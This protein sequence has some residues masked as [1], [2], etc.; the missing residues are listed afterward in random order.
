LVL[1]FISYS[2]ID[3]KF[4]GELKSHLSVLIRNNEISTFYDRDIAVG[5]YLDTS[6]R[7]NMEKASIIFLLVSSDFLGSDYCYDIEMKFAFEL[8]ATNQSRIV[9]V[10]IRPCDWRSTEL[11]KYLVA[12][13]DGV[14]ISLWPNKDSA[15]LDVVKQVRRALSEV[16]Q[17]EMFG[18]APLRQLPQTEAGQRAK[19]PQRFSPVIPRIRRERTDL[20]RS[21]YLRDSFGFIR[22]YF[23]E[24][25]RQLKISD[26]RVDF[27]IEPVTTRHFDVQVFIDGSLAAECAVKLQTERG[28][29]EITYSTDRGN[30]NSYNAAVGVDSDDYDVF[31]RGTFM[32][33]F[34]TGGRKERFSPDEVAQTFWGML[35]EQLQFS[36]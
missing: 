13:T 9:P 2:H 12:P 4:V 29:A 16:S 35:M 34:S 1:A 21:T 26:S 24:G 11:A 27:E 5:S 15:Y 7:Q 22:T 10:I 18:V 30:R 6:I 25:L 20:E 17:N 3:E 36:R 19:D 31:L 32:N 14:A 8:S 23:E 28:S 33:V